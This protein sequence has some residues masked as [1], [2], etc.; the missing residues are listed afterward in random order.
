MP[1]GLCTAP[2]IFQRV[3]NYL[4]DQLAEGPTCLWAKKFQ[5]LQECMEVCKFS[6]LSQNPMNL[7]TWFIK[8]NDLGGM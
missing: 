1:F 7:L 3:F 4:F 6:S 5:S 8:G 2:A